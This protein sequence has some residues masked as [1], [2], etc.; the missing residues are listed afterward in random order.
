[1]DNVCDGD[2]DLDFPSHM[3]RLTFENMAMSVENEQWLRII[4]LV[5]MSGFLTKTTAVFGSIIHGTLI[6]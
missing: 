2:S 5:T 4:E 6:Y 1:M 3:E